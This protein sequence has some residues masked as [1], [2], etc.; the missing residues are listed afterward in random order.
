MECKD[1]LRALLCACHKVNCAF[2]WV[3]HNGH[4]LTIQ[5]KLVGAG[6]LSVAWWFEWMNLGRWFEA[7]KRFITADWASY[8]CGPQMD[9][10]L[11]RQ[12]HVCFGCM[13]NFVKKNL[14]TCIIRIEG[15]F[16]LRWWHYKAM[17]VTHTW[18]LCNVL[19]CPS[20]MLGEKCRH[21][22]HDGAIAGGW[23]TLSIGHTKYECYVHDFPKFT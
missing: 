18:C 3:V 23:T 1:E 22:L 11:F 19:C 21:G 17:F 4:C 9:G 5:A 2:Y 12:Q 15:N 8:F 20:E 13:S 14:C 10:F 6:K 7:L 16:T